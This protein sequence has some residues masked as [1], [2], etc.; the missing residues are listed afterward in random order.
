MW[1]LFAV[2]TLVGSLRKT[3]RL[4]SCLDVFAV[5]DIQLAQLMLL[6]AAAVE[7]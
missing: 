2:T 3:F 1:L 6:C 4:V 7:Q 5:I